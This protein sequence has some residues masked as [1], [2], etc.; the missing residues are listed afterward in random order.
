[1][2][3]LD[4]QKPIFFKGQKVEFI[5]WDS[6]EEGFISVKLNGVFQ[7]VCFAELKN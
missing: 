1:M 4:Q 3:N 6:K 7:T 5:D 2:K